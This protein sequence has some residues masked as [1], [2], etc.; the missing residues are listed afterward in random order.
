MYLKL[1]RLPDPRLGLLDGFAVL[2]KDGLG[3]QVT[4]HHGPSYLGLVDSVDEM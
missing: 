1:L 3:E 4:P 2:R